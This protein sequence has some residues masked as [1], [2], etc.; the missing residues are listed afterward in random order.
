MVYSPPAIIFINNNISSTLQTHLVRQLQITEVI[1]GEIFD[2]RVA[3]DSDGYEIDGYI[4]ADGYFVDYVPDLEFTDYVTYVHS[5]N[6]RILVLR[7]FTDTTNRELADLV[8]FI[9]NG[10]AAMEFAPGYGPPSLSMSVNKIRLNF[11]GLQG[12]SFQVVKDTD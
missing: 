12:K 8:L 6:R 11:Y 9:K 3:S 2:A 5:T 10:I 1:T 7:D 4:D